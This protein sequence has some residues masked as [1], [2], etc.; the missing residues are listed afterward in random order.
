[1][2]NLYTPVSGESADEL[3]NLKRMTGTERI[4]APYEFQLF[5]T[6]KKG[7]VKFEDVVGKSMSVEITFGNEV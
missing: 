3:L 2:A 1:M 7:E 4:S 5:M 6:L